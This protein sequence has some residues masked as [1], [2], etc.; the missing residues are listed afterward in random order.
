MRST[1]GGSTWS[2]VDGP[3][4]SSLLTTN[5]VSVT[6]NNVYVGDQR[7]DGAFTAPQ[8]SLTGSAP[9]AR[10]AVNHS[11]AQHSTVRPGQL[12]RHVTE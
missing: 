10:P 11:G 7:T 3:I 12:A 6:A 5:V 1:N 2:L 8:A 9:T 4:E